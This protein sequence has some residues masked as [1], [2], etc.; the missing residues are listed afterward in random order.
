[1][2]ICLKNNWK[3]IDAKLKYKFYLVSVNK[4]IIINKILDKLH[5]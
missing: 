1:M 5:N 2:Q 4:Y 3:I